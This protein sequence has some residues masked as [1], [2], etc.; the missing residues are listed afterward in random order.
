MTV[1]YL[2]WCGSKVQIGVNGG[3][4][5]KLNNLAKIEK[6]IITQ[7]SNLPAHHA[8]ECAYSHVPISSH[9]LDLVLNG[10]MTRRNF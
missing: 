10:L 2:G 6:R 7:L 3:K 8:P 1:V 9:C 5:K 4:L